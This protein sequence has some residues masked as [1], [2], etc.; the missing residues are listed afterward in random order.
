M[1]FND[2]PKLRG[3]LWQA[4]CRMALAYFSAYNA[5]LGLPVGKHDIQ[6]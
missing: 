1:I 2:D 4:G 6:H 3:T 5:L